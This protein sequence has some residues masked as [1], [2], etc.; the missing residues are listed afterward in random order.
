M[1]SSDAR[2]INKRQSAQSWGCCRH[3]G[4]TSF[5]LQ[6]ESQQE[7][8]MSPSS[9]Q[10]HPSYYS[11]AREG[12]RSLCDGWPGRSLNI[13]WRPWRHSKAT[14]AGLSSLPQSLTHSRGNVWLWDL[15][16]TYMLPVP[17]SLDS[18]GICLYSCKMFCCTFYLFFFYQRYPLTEETGASRQEHCSF[19]V[20]P[21][22]WVELDKTPGV[23][24]C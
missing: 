17:V 7:W 24:G 5:T 3:N 8:E 4:V 2:A 22:D 18:I 19:P 13:L 11:S 9:P 20:H 15:V 21:I 16:L 6:I 14:G 23:T 10:P 1:F 12:G